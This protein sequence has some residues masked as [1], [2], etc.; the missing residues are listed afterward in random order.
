VLGA[1]LN[2]RYFERLGAIPDARILAAE[3]ESLTV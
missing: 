3:L 2:D 1:W